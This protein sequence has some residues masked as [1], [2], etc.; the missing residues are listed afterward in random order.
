MKALP[1]LVPLALLVWLFALAGAPMA[2]ADDAAPITSYKTDVELSTDGVASVTTEFTMDF[3]QLRGRGPWLYWAMRQE[4]GANPDEWYVFEYSNMSVSSPSGA[5]VET[6]TTEE[7]GLLGVRIGDENT[8]YDTPQDYVVTY[9]VTGLIVPD[10]AQSGLDEF[11]WSVFGGIQDFE[12]SDLEVSVTGPTTTSQSA[13]FYGPEYSQ[14]CTSSIQDSTAT[15]Q[16][17]SLSPGEGFQVVA[18]YPAGTFPG[19]TQQKARRTT[20]G[21]FFE[22]NPA[23]GIATAVVTAGAGLLLVRLYRRK[24]GDDVYLGLTPGLTPTDGSGG[25]TGKQRGKQT[26]AVQFQPPKGVTPGELGTL[27]DTTADNVDISATIIDLAVR[28]YI[29]ISGEREQVLTQVLPPPQEPLLPFEHQ[30]ISDLFQNGSQISISGLSH[31]RYAQVQPHA[32]EGLYNAVVQRGWFKRNP[33]V[34]QTLW[35]GLGVV[36]AAAGLFLTI[37][38]GASFGWGL[39]GIPIIVAGLAL[40]IMSGKFRSR[41]AEGSAYLAQGKGFELYLKTAEAD[42]IKFE[43]GIDVFSRYLPYAMIFGVA[44]RWAKIFAELGERGI[45]E[46]DLSWYYGANLYNY[47]WFTS[48]LNSMSHGL[49]S[50]MSSAV[51][52]GATSSTSGSSGFSGFSGGGGFGG[53]GGGSW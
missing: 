33:V 16:L 37:M 35:I 34:S 29:Q 38:L 6:Y 41:T 50:A 42:Q 8:F 47:M 21:N 11:N 40:A 27:M 13:C 3:S 43:E 1:K 32:K 15:Y 22:L 4:D 23:S 51:A 36:I 46:P 31:R 24:A 26:I 7:D 45:Y 9:D 53:G 18:G 48:S 12:I 19:V 14:E 49:S 20:A 17:D 30:L 39:V 52:A 25:T 5:N 10:Q 28:G 44:D 2:A